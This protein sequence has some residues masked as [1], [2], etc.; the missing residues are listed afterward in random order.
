MGNFQTSLGELAPYPRRNNIIRYNVFDGSAT[1]I[2]DKGP[3]SFVDSETNCSGSKVLLSKHPEWA[4]DI[5]HNVFTNNAGAAFYSVSDYTKFHHNLVYSG[6]KGYFMVDELRACQV[7]YKNEIYNNTFVDLTGPGI[8][9]PSQPT[10]GMGYDHDIYNNL[11][12]NPSHQAVIAIS[13]QTFVWDLTY[14]HNGY[15]IGEATMARYLNF[16]D[17]NFTSWTGYGYD[18]SSLHEAL[19]VEANYQLP[20]GSNAIGAGRDSEDLG[21]FESDWFDDAGYSGVDPPPPTEG[22]STAII[23]GGSTFNLNGGSTLLIQ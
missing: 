12:I 21:A 18:D 15:D 20:P 19:T 23:G 9:I 4:N 17:I 14:D 13:G 10:T 11:H 6:A 8:T 1:S 5:H 7:V 3:N 2:K 16:G 22:G